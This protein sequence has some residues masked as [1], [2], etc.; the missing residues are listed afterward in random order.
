MAAMCLIGVE[1]EVVGT[2]P[3]LT[4]EIVAVVHRPDCGSVAP[5]SRSAG[6]LL[7]FRGAASRSAGPSL[8]VPGRSRT[9]RGPL[10]VVRWG[11]A[12]R[13]AGPLLWLRGAGRAV[14]GPGLCLVQQR[15]ALDRLRATAG[16]GWVR[17]I[18]AGMAAGGPG[19]RVA[20][21]KPDQL[22]AS[23]APFHEPLAIGAPRCEIVRV[24]PQ[25]LFQG[26]CLHRSRLTAASEIPS[27]SGSVSADSLCMWQRRAKAG[28]RGTSWCAPSSLSS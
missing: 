9:R 8:W 11:A 3:R 6:P 7:W 17:V 5:A 16:A 23:V 28:C 18:D 22:A 4:T 15:G 12:N 14:K 2:G 26:C 1:V 27:Q 21:L 24:I 10:A 25:R 19:T 20:L 13:R